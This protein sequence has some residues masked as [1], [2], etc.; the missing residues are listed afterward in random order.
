MAEAMRTLR[1]LAMRTIAG[2]S[3]AWPAYCCE[4]VDL[5]AQQER[6]SWRKPCA[7]KTGRGAAAAK[8]FQRDADGSGDLLAGA[9]SR[10]IGLAATRG[11]RGGARSC[12]D[13]DAGWLA[14]RH[15][16]Y[17]DTWRADHDRGCEI[18]ACGLRDSLVPVF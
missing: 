3:A 5:L 1:L 6:A 12:D 10:A 17:A 15:G 2:Y 16:G 7:R 4:F 18:I 11:E 8:L 9:V 13:R 14:V